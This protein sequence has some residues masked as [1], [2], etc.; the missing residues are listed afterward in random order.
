MARRT[1]DVSALAGVAPFDR[2]HPR[3][4]APLAPHADRVTVLP[5]VT[6]AREGHRSHEVVVVLSGQVAVSRDGRPEGC[7]GPGAVIGARAELEGTAHDATCVATS[8]VSALVLHGP[9]FRW[10]AQALPGLTAALDHAAG[11]P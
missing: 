9:A 4:L 3:D 1:V 5:G 7:L 2:Y 10:A 6:L 8:A 11:T